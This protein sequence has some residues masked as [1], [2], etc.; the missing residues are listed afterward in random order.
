MQS[1]EALLDEYNRIHRN[2]VNRKLHSAGIPLVMLGILGLVALLPSVQVAGHYLDP[3]AL[4]VLAMLF[5][6]GRW[7]WP[8][9]L[10]LQLTLL[11]LLAGMTAVLT[12]A[13]A[14]QDIAAWL[15]AGAIVIGTVL[16]MV[17]H[18]LF[19]GVPAQF[20]QNPLFLL[21]GPLDLARSVA[22]RLGWR[23]QG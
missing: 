20:D 14:G 3:L 4:W 17:G 10:G 19:E 21:A 8:L 18:R 12:R 15:Y 11:L 5:V 22:E 16:H 23:S 9:A 6:F 1:L 2:P 13:G 7:S